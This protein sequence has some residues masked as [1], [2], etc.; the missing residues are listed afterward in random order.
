MAIATVGLVNRSRKAAMLGAAAV[1]ATALA[2]GLTSPAV[3]PSAAA[4]DLNAVTTGPLLKIAEIAGIN[5]IEI[6]DVP[7]VGSITVDLTYAKNNPVTLADAINAYP[8]GGFNALGTSFK[9]QP[10]GLLGTAILAG[11]GPGAFNAGLAYEA[12]LS[13]AEGNTLPGYTPM[14]ASG[15][16]NSVTGAPPPC[17]P[18]FLCVQGTNITNLAVVEVNNPGT[19][20][21]N[22]AQ[23]RLGRGCQPSSISMV[24]VMVVV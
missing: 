19:P 8:L 24:M 13:S 2:A 20:N 11:S 23:L 21:G 3:L 18:S 9:R 10:G 4:L 1:T 16:V 22:A 12:L 15:L 7:V 5:T 14:V 6:P 17:T